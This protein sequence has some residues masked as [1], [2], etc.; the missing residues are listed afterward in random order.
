MINKQPNTG[1][2]I[3]AN[4]Q[5]PTANIVTLLFLFLAIMKKKMLSIPLQQSMK[6]LPI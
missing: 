4:S 5:Q 3:Y 6:R 1:D 2:K